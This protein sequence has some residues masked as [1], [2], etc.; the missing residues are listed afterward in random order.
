MSSWNDG[1]VTE[2]RYTCG[3]YAEL[4]PS[5]LAL[6]CLTKNVE[7]PGLGA[8]PLRLLELGCGQGLS[9]NIIA[10]ANPH[11]EYTAIDF[12][13]AHIS[14]ASALARE[15]GTPNLRF[16][17][18]SF[19]EIAAD[20][21]LGQFDV[22]TLHGVY[23]WVSAENREHIIRIARDKLK[24]GGLLY[25][26][27]NCYPGWAPVAPIRRIFTDAAATTPKAPI[28]DR[29]DQGFRLF[30]RLKDVKARYIAGIPSLVERIDKTKNLP[31]NYV[32]HEYLNEEWTVFY[33]PDVAA[34]MARAKLTFIASAHLIDNVDG[35]NLT[36]DQIALLNEMKDPIQRE[37]LRDIIVGQQ[38]RRDLFVKGSPTL[39]ALASRDK[40]LD[41][42]FALTIPEKDVPRKIV[43]NLGEA[44]LQA[45]VYNPVLEKLD[46]GPK[47][48]RELLADPVIAAL[49]WTSVAQA[50][51]L[52]VGQ[53]FCHLALP[54]DGKEKER[55]LRAKALNLAIL[56]R[57][58][59]NSEIMNLASP[60]IGA[61]VAADAFT[62][63]RLLADREGVTERAPFI[64]EIFKARGQKFIKDNQPLEGDAANL[65]E[66]RALLAKFDE[67]QMRILNSLKVK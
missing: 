33:F 2:V 32:A 34:D 28:F 53:N 12:N 16:C 52:L 15:A 62:Q 43:T 41:L 17:E 11:I 21:S 59:E 65:A 58:R 20:D 30:D 44:E 50:L 36:A 19:A 66:I 4:V 64:W 49:G 5:R 10:A 47:S 25:V 46:N 60:V 6:A 40:W 57:A 56:R 61:G 54:E 18:A 8:Q 7:A 23:T 48:L 27:Y 14:F 3:Y 1:Y 55:V 9:A 22:I 51:N 63:L 26:S 45:K 39:G 29:L 38:F 42:R 35:L 37:W 24:T 31:K 67:S 13:P